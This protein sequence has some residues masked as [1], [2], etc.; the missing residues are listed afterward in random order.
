MKNFIDQ[1]FIRRWLFSWLI[2]KMNYSQRHVNSYKIF[3]I[4]EHIFILE[5]SEE[6]TI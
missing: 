3:S 4:S 1:F 5:S 6:I 2:I